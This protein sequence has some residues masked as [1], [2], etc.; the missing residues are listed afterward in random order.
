MLEHLNT[1]QLDTDQHN[2]DSRNS[3]LSSSDL[4]TTDPPVVHAKWLGSTK[5][6]HLSDQNFEKLCPFFA[7]ITTFMIQKT[8]ENTTQYAK[9]VMNY[10]SMT[11]H[12]A[13]HFKLLNHLCL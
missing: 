3:D 10:P 7:W 2:E 12:S 1:D 6:R 11:C 13:S 5:H 4:G 8:L 9:A